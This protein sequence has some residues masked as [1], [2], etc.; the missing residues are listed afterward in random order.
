VLGV[1][2]YTQLPLIAAATAPSRHLAVGLAA[3]GFL[4]VLGSAAMGWRAL[5]SE[6]VTVRPEH[7]DDDIVARTVRGMAKVEKA[8]RPL[9]VVMAKSFLVLGA[10]VLIAGGVAYLI[11]QQSVGAHHPTCLVSELAPQL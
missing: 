8:S 5:I 11:N 10:A 7:P 4:L 2:S 1:S 3:L 6:G 9:Y